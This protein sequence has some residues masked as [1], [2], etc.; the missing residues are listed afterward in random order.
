VHAVGI[1]R[2]GK[3]HL[4]DSTCPHRGGPLHLGKVDPA[5]GVITCPWHGIG[6]PCVR[7]KPVTY[8]TVRVRD[9]VSVICAGEREIRPIHTS[10]LQFLQQSY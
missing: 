6:T 2:A 1:I 5:S 7:L 3:W 10:N 9:R 8:P 4:V